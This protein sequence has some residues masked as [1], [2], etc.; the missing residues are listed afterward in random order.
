MHFINSHL[1]YFQNNCG[2]FIEEQGERFHQDVSLIE[3]RY[4]GRI[5]V[6]MLADYCWT[7]SVSV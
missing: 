6:N 1:D 7:N 3:E 4:K 2:Y 5:I